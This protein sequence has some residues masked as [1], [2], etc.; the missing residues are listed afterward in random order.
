[1][2]DGAVPVIASPL[3]G[4]SILTQCCR[5]YREVTCR[6]PLFAGLRGRVHWT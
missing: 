5:R 2:A 4:A 6:K 1:M 3:L